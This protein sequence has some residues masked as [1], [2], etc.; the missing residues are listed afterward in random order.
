MNRLVSR[1]NGQCDQCRGVD[2]GWVS[3]VT[4]AS[5]D[6]FPSDACCSMHLH[7]L[8]LSNHEFNYF[9]SV[10]E[11]R[12]W[13][14]LYGSVVLLF[15]LLVCLTGAGT[16]MLRLVWQCMPCTISNKLNMNFRAAMLTML[17]MSFTWTVNLTM[18]TV[19][20]GQKYLFSMCYDCFPL[21]WDWTGC[22]DSSV[23]AVFIYKGS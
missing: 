18:C 13:Q 6:G 10:H 5:L 19:W 20:G 17:L 8:L 12:W 11:D 9:I 22:P 15:C 16:S 7:S 4:T 14:F 23:F 2:G 3:M 1:E 21:W